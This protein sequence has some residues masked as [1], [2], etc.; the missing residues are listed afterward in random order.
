MKK[1]PLFARFTAKLALL[2]TLTAAIS[3]SVATASHAAEPPAPTAISKVI[4]GVGFYQSV[5][6]V[7]QTIKP[8][9]N[10]LQ[11]IEADIVQLPVAK[12]SEVHLICRGYT[13][14]AN[15][16]AEVAFVFSDDNLTMVEAN[17]GIDKALA[18]VISEKP[19]AFM[20]YEVDFPQ[21]I[22]KEP[23]KDSV[24]FMTNDTVHPHLFLTPNPHM[25]ANKSRIVKHGKNVNHPAILQ[26]GQ[27][28]DDLQ[29]LMEKQCNLSYVEQIDKI[30]LANKPQTQTQINCYGYDYA[31]Y[32]RKIEAVFGDGILQQAWIL[33]GKGEESRIREMLIAKYGEP[34][35][36][37]EE[38]E[39]FN[40]WQVALR[41]DKPEVL[42]VS[43]TIGRLLAKKFAVQ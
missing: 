42:M 18:N 3:A 32:N 29:P 2:T 37:T 30:W 43:K 33:T 25:R 19:M 38:Y 41:K 11:I 28:I 35:L 4:E 5:T 14:M 1:S 13:H 34:Q 7:K 10:D 36:I 15:Q 31:G 23:A 20:S 40:D 21:L 6:Q 16:L 27:S 8:R 12:N 24:W 17:G 9:C 22:I 26:F 39:V